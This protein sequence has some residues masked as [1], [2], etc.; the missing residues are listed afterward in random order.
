[1]DAWLQ[2]T[3]YGRGAVVMSMIQK[4]VRGSLW[5][6]VSEFG[7][8]ALNLAVTLVLSRKLLPAEFGMFGMVMVFTGFVGYFSEFGLTTGL[9]QRKDVDELD[10]NSVFWAAVALTVLLYT[11][12]Y[13]CAPLI[14]L[15]YKE[16]RLTQITRVVFASLLLMPVNY[17]PEVIQ[18]KKLEYGKITLSELFSVVVSGTVVIILAL[19][20]FGV[21]SLVWQSIIKAGSRAAAL[22]YLTHWKPK[23]ELSWNRI[24]R[25]LSIGAGI[26]LNNLLM[27]ASDNTDYLLVGKLLGESPL[28]IYTMA[29]RVSKYPMQKLVG[30]FGKMLFPAF[31]T[32]SDDPDRVRRNFARLLVFF[33]S[34]VTPILICGYFIS[35]PLVHMLLG[36]KWNATIPLVRVFMIN[37]VLTTICFQNQPILVALNKIHK[38][39]AL[40]F[41]STVVL[42]IAGFIGIRLLGILG[43]AIAFTAVT[44]LFLLGTFFMLIQT[45]RV[46]FR[47]ILC[48]IR[49]SLLKD[50]LFALFI[51]LVTWSLNMVTNSDFLRAS[52]P[53]VLLCVWLIIMNRSDVTNLRESIRAHF[54][55]L[56]R[57]KSG[58]DD[59][60]GKV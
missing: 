12:V 50:I 32:F 6:S 58:A 9:I 20:N 4:L 25:L 21:W 3:R 16:P 23:F 46:P 11:I 17:L 51:G 31:A 19:L 56:R 22:I 2:F 36:D 27:F 34:W 47:Q 59:T 18:K 38:W 37:L 40:Q 7:S 35:Q 10:T 30:V 8:Q 5:N 13:F 48:T 43:M 45:I 44:S 57:V 14:S 29:F 41:V 15:F 26:T 53:A 49:A 60:R 33:M 54:A 39:N 28:G 1:M 55:Q 42:A 24:K 52:L